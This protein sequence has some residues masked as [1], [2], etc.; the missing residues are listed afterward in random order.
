MR[1]DSV[2][3]LRFI[4]PRFF[5][6]HSTAVEHY[7]DTVGVVG[8]KPAG[9]TGHPPE[10]S[11]KFDRL[12]GGWPQAPL[13]GYAERW[14]FNCWWTKRTSVRCMSRTAYTKVRNN[15]LFVGTTL[16]GTRL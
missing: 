9:P 6:A 3:R 12:R 7:L 11:K 8:S 1:L 15:F 5:R 14:R 10:P 13:P 2:D 16:I 4:R